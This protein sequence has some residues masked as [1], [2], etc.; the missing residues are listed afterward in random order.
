MDVW[1]TFS[2]LGAYIAPQTYQVHIQYFN[3]AAK[4]NGGGKS[5]RLEEEGMHEIDNELYAFS[6]ISLGK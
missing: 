6:S 5:E 1:V 2:V 4:T 3:V